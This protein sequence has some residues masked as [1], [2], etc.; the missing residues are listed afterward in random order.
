M[1]DFGH[2]ELVTSVAVPR[3]PEG[4]GNH[5][6]PENV[7][8]GTTVSC[9]RMTWGLASRLR[10]YCCREAFLWAKLLQFHC[11]MRISSFGLAILKHVGVGPGVQREQESHVRG[12]TGR[13]HALRD[14]L[15]C[16]DSGGDDVIEIVFDFAQSITVGREGALHK[17][18]ALAE[19]A[20]ACLNRRQ[21][22]LNV[23]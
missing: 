23:I 8:A 1:L 15:S 2:V 16:G 19:E 17:G 9:N 20:E 10:R 22:A 7:V 4:S 5:S 6:Y 21:H 11:Q 12:W 13:G 18:H 3:P 14:R